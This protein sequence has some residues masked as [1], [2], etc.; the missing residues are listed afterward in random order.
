MQWTAAD[1][2]IHRLVMKDLM[3]QLM[4]VAV[5]MMHRLVIVMNVI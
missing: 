5:M 3:V 2:V 4:V 1:L